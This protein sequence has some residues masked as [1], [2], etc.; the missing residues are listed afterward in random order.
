MPEKELE[1]I[2]EFIEEMEDRIGRKNSRHLKKILLKEMVC[3]MFGARGDSSKKDNNCSDDIFYLFQAIEGIIPVIKKERKSVKLRIQMRN[4]MYITFQ[5]ILDKLNLEKVEI[6]SDDTKNKW[7]IEI[8]Q[9]VPQNR[10][11]PYLNPFNSLRQM[12]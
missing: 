2:I 10:L 9:G 1:Q 11:I 4:G 7:V 6:P 8:K 12:F 3:L 5:E